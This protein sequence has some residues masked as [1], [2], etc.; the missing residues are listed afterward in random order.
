LPGL[1]RDN[2]ALSVTRC[3]KFLALPVPQRGLAILGCCHQWIFLAV[4]SPIA[5]VIVPELNFSER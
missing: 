1:G 5:A 2:G 3:D 4:G